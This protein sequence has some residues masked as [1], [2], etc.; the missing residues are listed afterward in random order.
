MHT[1][2][3]ARQSHPPSKLVATQKPQSQSVLVLGPHRSGTSAVARV[4]NLL[5]VELGGQMLPPK[6][7]NPR[8]YW[9]HQR[10][11]ELH[12]RLL[13]RAGSAWHDYRP[14][15]P[16]WRNLED[17]EA[18]RC[19]LRSF[20]EEEFRGEP[21]WGAKDP[22]LCHLLPLWIDT[23]E[24]IGAVCLFVIVV[25]NPLEVVRSVERRDGFRRSKCVLLYLAEMLAALRHTEG[26]RRAFI[27]YAG[28]LEDWR[29][30]VTETARQLQ[31]EWPHDPAVRADE[32]DAFLEPGERHHRHDLSE[33]G[34]D[35]LLPGWSLD[36]Y[37]AL[38]A[39]GRGRPETL[40]P[41]L[42]RAEDAF[43]SAAAL[44]GPELEGLEG[45][46]RKEQARLERRAERAESELFK[47]QRQ[48]TSILSSRL[49]RATRPLRHAWYRI[50]RIHR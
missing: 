4:L 36:L 10:I 28:L 15:P 5:G 16:G 3:P 11:F 12:E 17:V 20:F 13:S 24:E 37:E 25:R 39:A 33:L 29:S 6:F 43:Q 41:A 26:R 8:G 31:L 45:E 23:L 35:P 38:E 21:L 27:S 32:I 1:V 40:E 42:R 50:A 44:F 46:L 18:L 49:Y 47:V 9:E 34:D 2:T 48:L 7:D 19:E 30:A 14:L 22:R